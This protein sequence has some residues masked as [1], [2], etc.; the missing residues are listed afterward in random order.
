MTQERHRIATRHSGLLAALI[1]AMMP[2][3][4]C[5]RSTCS[6]VTSAC[7]ERCEAMPRSCRGNVHVFLVNGFDPFDISGIGDAK[8]TLHGLGFKNVYS[9]QFYH[10]GG[11]G[12]EIKEVAADDPNAHFV[13]V[14]VGMGVDAAVSLAEKVSE[15]GVTIDLLA[16]VDSPFWSN[17]AG[18]KPSN[19]QRVL[20]LHGQTNAW[21]PWTPGIEEDISV[22]GAIWP[23]V[24]GHPLIIETLA[25]E[26]ATLA[27]SIPAE[28]EELPAAPVV[29]PVPRPDAAPNA[30]PAAAKSFLTPATSLEGR[31]VSRGPV[32]AI[33]VRRE[34]SH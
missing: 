23:G 16:S 10:A 20:S 6:G 29:G 28:I 26:L 33:P 21:L 1:F 32:P 13:V 27:G 25:T 19:V 7:Q 17:A 30:T 4:M 14:G 8:S 34:I 5:L 11:F 9:G 12:D 3:C 18:K 2:G 31:D 22:P 15:Y 24:S